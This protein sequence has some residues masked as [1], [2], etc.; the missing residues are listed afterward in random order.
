[1]S[2]NPG[3]LTRLVLAAILSIQCTGCL[4]GPDFSEPSAPVANKW[5]ESKDPSVISAPLETAA[6]R[7]DWDWWTVFHDPVLDRLIRL[8]YEQNLTLVSAGTR[9]LD[10]RAQ[11]GVAIGEFFPPL[12]QGKG[13][14]IYERPSHADPTANPLA[15][16]L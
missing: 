1:M 9:V 10:A 2:A 14:I 12:Q 4:V 16:V 7:A 3:G 13:S 8:A 5:L 6:K 11:L 15:G